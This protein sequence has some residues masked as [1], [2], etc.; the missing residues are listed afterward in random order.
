MQSCLESLWRE[1]VN[2]CRLASR[3]LFNSLVPIS[4]RFFHSC[5]LCFL[6]AGL[7]LTLTEDEV[8]LSVKIPPVDFSYSCFSITAGALTCLPLKKSSPSPA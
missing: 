2:Y 3:V 4:W 5:S 6:V 8:H 7:L 1:T